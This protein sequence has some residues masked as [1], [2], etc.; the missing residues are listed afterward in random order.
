VR[1]AACLLML[2]AQSW[3]ASVSGYI[4][5][6]TSHNGAGT[7]STG[8][9]SFHWDSKTGSLTD[10]RTAA[11]ASSPSFLVMH[12]NGR[13]LYAVNEG[14]STDADRIIAFAVSDSKSSG[15]LRGLG[16]VSSMGKGP[17]HLSLDSSGRWLFVANY[18]SGSIAVYP[19]RSDGTLGDARQTIQ[20]QDPAAADKSP[21]RPHAH[22][23]V[24]S[25]D[26]RFLLSVDLGLDKVFIYR[27]DSISGTLTANDPSAL[28]FPSKYGPRHLVFSKD[29][30]RVYLLTELTAKLVTLTWDSARGSLR[31]MAETS[32]LPPGYAGQPSGAELALSTDGRFLY[33]SNRAQSNSITAFRISPDALPT[34]IGSVGSGGQTP[35]FIVIDPSGRFVLAANQDSNDIAAF[36]IDPVS[37]AL[38]RKY[39][40]SSLPAPVDI[41]FQPRTLH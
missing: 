9:Y 2:S 3:G 19:V 15:Q 34:V 7:G 5:T 30:R 29:A 1:F 35:R 27:F 33:A 39:G 8:I 38:T 25:P 6:Y 22:E 21:K 17:C 23:V 14:G 11:T 18:G 20:Q 32:A 41:V 12:S 16:S 24:P 40:A 4:G 10:I 13:F 31:E 37:G 36:R 28:Q 26:G